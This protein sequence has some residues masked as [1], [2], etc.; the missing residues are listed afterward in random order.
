MISSLALLL[1]IFSSD[2]EASM[3]IKELKLLPNLKYEVNFLKKRREPVC[4]GGKA[5]GWQGEGPRIESAPA[6]LSLQ[7]S[8]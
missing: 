1:V 8:F 2:G 4:P 5:S 3:A 7:K 6:L